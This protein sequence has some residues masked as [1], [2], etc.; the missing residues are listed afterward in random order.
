MA[1]ASAVEQRL[2]IL[3]YLQLDHKWPSMADKITKLAE[4]GLNSNEIGSIVGKAP[5]LCYRYSFQ[6]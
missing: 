2:N 1:A 3:I 4:L 5:K 6:R